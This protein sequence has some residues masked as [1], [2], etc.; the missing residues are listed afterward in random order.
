VIPGAIDARND[1]NLWIVDGAPREYRYPQGLGTLSEVWSHARA[2]RADLFVRAWPLGV[3]PACAAVASIV[4]FVAPRVLER[5]LAYAALV[6][7]ATGAFLVGASGVRA[8]RSGEGGREYLE[9]LP[10][11][12]SLAA[13]ELARVAPAAP[14]V[15]RAVVGGIVIEQRCE[16]PRWYVGGAVSVS[17]PYSPFAGRVVVGRDQAHGFRAIWIDHGLSPTIVW[18]GSSAGSLARRDIADRAAP[19]CWCT[20][21]GLAGCVLAMM[22]LLLRNRGLSLGRE[23]W[24]PATVTDDGR[25]LVHD[26]ETGGESRALACVVA[27]G[28]VFVRAAPS[29]PPQGHYR[30]AAR[31]DADC[32]P[33]RVY[34]ARLARERAVRTARLAMAAALAAVGAAPLAVVAGSSLPC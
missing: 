27:P 28:P 8:A 12:A 15:R 20:R 1:L 2:T 34:R 31:V 26:G 24:I 4:T 3:V 22:A 10:V 29:A 33:A 5:V 18:D 9:R 7:V 19:P 16:T 17:G 25:L 23:R 11:E 21:L 30:A 6:A 32:V 14:R 13:C